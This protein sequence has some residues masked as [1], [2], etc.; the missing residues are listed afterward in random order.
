M[1]CTQFEYPAD[2]HCNPCPDK[3]RSC[4][5]A[6][7]CSACVDNA[8]IKNEMCKCE[9]GYNGTDS[10]EFINFS[11]SLVVNSDN[12]LNLTFSDDLTNRISSL[13]LSL[14]IQNIEDFSWTIERMSDSCYFISII[15]LEEIK[16]GD[17]IVV[18]IKDITTFV[19]INNGLLLTNRYFGTLNSFSPIIE[20]TVLSSISAQTTAAVQIAIGAMVA[21]NMINPNP[22][23][24]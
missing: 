23:S 10:C 11:L 16:E 20:E 3:C 5:S 8:A 17:Q 14:E 6:T 12:S 22:A 4:L 9:L 2:G 15:S 1:Q 18:N 21:L 24:F 13:D 19:S 7:T